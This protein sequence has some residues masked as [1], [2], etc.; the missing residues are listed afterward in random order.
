MAR[1]LSNRQRF[2]AVEEGLPVFNGVADDEG[3]AAEELGLVA[4]VGLWPVV[5]GGEALRSGCL[6]AG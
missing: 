3:W 6:C 2:D 5:V 1:T 4:E